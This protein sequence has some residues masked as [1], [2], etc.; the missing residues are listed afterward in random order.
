MRCL[1]IGSIPRASSSCAASRTGGDLGA[2]G[3]GVT[4]AAG[5]GSPEISKAVGVLDWKPR[6]DL[7]EGLKKTIAYFEELCLK[8]HLRGKCYTY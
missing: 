6:T 1:G 3:G 2:P 8:S 4:P 7:K 5:N